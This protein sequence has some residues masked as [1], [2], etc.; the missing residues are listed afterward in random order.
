[1][2]LR[3]FSLLIFFLRLAPPR[4]RTALQGAGH[5]RNRARRTGEKRR[6]GDTNAEKKKSAWTDTATAAAIDTV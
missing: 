5:P 6:K 1:M 3:G 4:S 2:V